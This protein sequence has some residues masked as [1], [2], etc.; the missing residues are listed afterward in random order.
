MKNAKLDAERLRF[1]KEERHRRS[2]RLKDYDYSQNAAYFV[3]I[4]THERECLLGNISGEE[5]Q[6]NE[7]GQV[8]ANCW[9]WLGQQY[10]YVY[11]DEWI[12]MPNHLHGIIVI[13][14]E[15]YNGLH[16]TCKGG[17]RTGL[18]KGIKRKPL[19]RLI[20]AFKT[21][22]AKRINDI[23]KT[24]AAPVWQRNYY[25]HIIR[26]ERDLESIR[27]Y[28]VSNSFTWHEDKEN[29]ERMK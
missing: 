3:T 21:V 25:E 14:D 29:P 1:D 7:I 4:C 23:R 27:Q 22:S 11:M 24:P 20:G 26:N 13:A 8:V 2:I 10:D 5:M 18:T 12:I 15:P 19:G 28:I 16:C 6:L 9:R 17:S